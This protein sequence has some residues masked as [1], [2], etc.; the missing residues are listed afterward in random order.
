MWMN[1]LSLIT[2]IQDDDS[3]KPRVGGLNRSLHKMLSCRTDHEHH[4][5]F[6]IQRGL[7]ISETLCLPSL[8]IKT[9]S[10]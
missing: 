2:I 5:N 7:M 8:A 3:L 9:Q 1:F 4:I 6:V 10:G